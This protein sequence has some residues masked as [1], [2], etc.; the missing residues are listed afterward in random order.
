MDVRHRF[1]LG[2]GVVS[3]TMATKL[4]PGGDIRQDW[5]AVNELCDDF[6]ALQK[7]VFQLRQDAQRRQ[8][9]AGGRALPFQIYQTSTW[10]KYKVTTGK[11]KPSGAI[12]V[13]TDVETEFT[14]TSGVAEY[15]FWLELTNT[16]AVVNASAT[17]PSEW[18]INQIPIGSVDTL[19]GLATTTAIINQFYPHHLY[20][21]CL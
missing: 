14:I 1:A 10:L 18:T 3:V 17:G 16:T 21:P 7:L 8:I 5:R 9:Y 12:I 15:W 6:I 20:L 11:F 4:Q 13:P 19:T 2:F